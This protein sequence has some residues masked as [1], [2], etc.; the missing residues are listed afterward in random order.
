MIR[1]NNQISIYNEKIIYKAIR[2]TGPGGQHVNKVSTAILLKYDLK[3]VVYPDW[4]IS[5]LKNEIINHQLSNHRFILIKSK[6]FKSQSRNK[7]EALNR[8]IALFKIASFRPKKRKMNQIPY[9][10]KQKR[11]KI[12]KLHSKKKLLRISP[13]IDD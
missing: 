4:F 13:K 1:I 2:S 8:L 7:K 11:L 5:N 6:K 9:S 3:C 12:K 10:S